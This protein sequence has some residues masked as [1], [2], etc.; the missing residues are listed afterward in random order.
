VSSVSLVF[1]R[2]CVLLKSTVKSI[3]VLLTSLAVVLPVSQSANAELNVGT[4]GVKRG[5]EKEYLQYQLGQQ[6]LSDALVIPGC[7]VGSGTGCNKTGTVLQQLLSTNGGPSYYDLVIRAAGGQQNYQNFAT[8]YGNNPRLSEIPFASFWRKE[9]PSILDGYQYVLGQPVGRTP[10]AG[11]GAVTQNFAWSPISRGNDALSPRQGLLDFKYSFGYELLREVSKIPN[12][13]Q[14]IRAL[15][16]PPDMTQFYLNNLSRGL[17]ALK[18]GNQQEL[19][20]S[21][22]RIVSFPYSTTSIAAGDDGRTPLGV[23]KELDNIEGIPIAGEELSPDIALLEGETFL[24]E[25]GTAIALD[26]GTI[27]GGGFNFLPYTPVLLLPLLALI[28]GGDG[29]S[30]QPVQTPPDVNQPPTATA[31]ATATPTPTPPPQRVDEPSTVM[32]MVSLTP[33]MCVFLYKRRITKTKSYVK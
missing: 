8:F 1:I 20:Q 31:T 24:L 30:S 5:L 15:D 33:L 22:L 2:R 28:G 14:Q 10:V 16:L 11:L 13:E 26:V 21:I 29:G 6:N 19:Q 25:S 9:S 32:A 27:G 4:R 7:I 3:V 18:T 12:L 23:P 17:N